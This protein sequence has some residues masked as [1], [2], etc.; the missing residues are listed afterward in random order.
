MEQ[1]IRDFEAIWRAR[2]PQPVLERCTNDH[3]ILPPVE[4]N[5]WFAAKTT[6]ERD[7]I[8]TAYRTHMFEDYEDL[9]DDDEW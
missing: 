8:V 7:A 4:R 9:E 2:I 1:R 3:E 5:R 6:A